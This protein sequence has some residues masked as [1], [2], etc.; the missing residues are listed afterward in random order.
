MSWSAS[1]ESSGKPNLPSTARANV[2]SA[3]GFKRGRRA[4]ITDCQIKARETYVLVQDTRKAPAHIQRLSTEMK[5]LHE[6]LATIQRLVEKVQNQTD[7]V[8][9]DILENLQKFITNCIEVFTDVRKVLN[10]SSK[11]DCDA[12]MG[13]WK[14]FLWA[15]FRRDDVVVL[16]QT[17]NS[18]KAM[19]N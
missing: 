13:A 9:S 5:S 10:T 12:S 3:V 14:G 1:R 11:A 6:L 4:R 2:N 17:L 15:T 19:L 8:I 16:Q 7:P 18:Y